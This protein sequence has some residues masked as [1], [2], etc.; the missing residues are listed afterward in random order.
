M[1]QDRGQDEHEV[2]EAEDQ[3]D[4]EEKRDG[5]LHAAQIQ[6]DEER[7]DREAGLQFQRMKV[8]R[9]ELKI[10]STPETTETEI[11]RM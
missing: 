3:K 1:A 8:A 2:G 6:D 4:R 10:A 7:E 5:F 9:Q 11:V